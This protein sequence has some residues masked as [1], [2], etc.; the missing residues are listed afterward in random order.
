MYVGGN[1]RVWAYDYW[2][3]NLWNVWNG[4]FDRVPLPSGLEHAVVQSIAGDGGEEIYVAFEGSNGIWH[5]H[6]NLWTRAS[7]PGV[8]SKT[9]S[10]LSF[11]SARR[12]WAGYADGRIAMLEHGSA[13]VFTLGDGKF[14]SVMTIYHD[15]DR[16]WAGG[17]NGIAVFTGD[18]F[19]V[20]QV[21]EGLEVRGI[22]GVV[23]S[24]KRDLWLNGARGVLRVP[25]GEIEMALAVPAYRFHAETFDSRD[26]VSGGAAQ[27]ALLHCR[28]RLDWPPLVRDRL[29][30]G[31]DRPAGY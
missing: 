16:V 26:G 28:R 9:P 7:A 15:R 22:S 8:P 12:L 20:L 19:R 27:L 14:G 4:K 24:A 21:M 25:S 17:T 2:F 18:G 6:D 1:G 13:R 29:Q 23:S 30:L 31:L 5:W 10:C 11:D 3:G